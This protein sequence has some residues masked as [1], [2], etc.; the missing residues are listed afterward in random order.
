MR[1][2]NLVVGNRKIGEAYTWAYPAGKNLGVF[3]IPTYSMKVSGW[4]DDGKRSER[5]FEVFRFGVMAKKPTEAK[6]VGLAEQ[7]T[8]IIKLW[9]PKYSVHSARSLERGAWQVYDNFLI[10]DG[11]DDPKREIYASIG[12]VEICNGPKGFDL[13]N[14]YLISLSGAKAA[15]RDAKLAEM[16]KS[17]GMIVTYMKAERP[18]LEPL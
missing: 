8:H 15:T 18:K 17:G 7:Q 3:V 6:I 12:C 5:T 4:L 16:G 14:D 13:F 9:R 10:H 1:Q 2:I 11:P